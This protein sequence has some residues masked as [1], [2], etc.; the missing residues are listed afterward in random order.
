MHSSITYDA[1]KRAVLRM[2]GEP[3]QRVKREEVGA[4]M[5]EWG[6][7]CTAC[8]VEMWDTCPVRWCALHALELRA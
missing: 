6:C 1:P 7:G 3:K 2:L 4:T 8:V 5:L